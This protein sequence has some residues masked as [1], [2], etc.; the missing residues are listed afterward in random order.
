MNRVMT[1]PSSRMVGVDIIRIVAALMVVFLHF[2]GV[3]AGHQPAVVFGQVIHAFC[4]CA[5]PFFLLASG[6]FYPRLSSSGRIKRHLSKLLWITIASSVLYI[7]FSS[8]YTGQSLGAF[9]SNAFTAPAIG[10]WLSYNYYPPI[11]GGHFWYLYAALYALVICWLFDIFHCSQCLRIVVIPMFAFLLCSSLMPVPSEFVRSF[12]GL[13]LPYIVLGRCVSEGLFDKWLKKISLKGIIVLIIVSSILLV[14]EALFFSFFYT[15]DNPTREHHIFALPL[16]FFV[17]V[18]STRCESHSRWAFLLSTIGRKY[19]A[20]VYVFHICV[21]L[22]IQRLFPSVTLVQS[23]LFNI[24]LTFLLSLL[25]SMVVVW[26]LGKVKTV[27][28]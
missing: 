9:L 10:K 13:A 25:L 21:G 18:L 23:M 24:P 11:A 4:R 2:S 26:I 19:S 6:Y 7:F 3:R 14:G 15:P 20:G 16:T 8:W 12:F 22:L 27:K 28:A 17:F 1:Q 5:V